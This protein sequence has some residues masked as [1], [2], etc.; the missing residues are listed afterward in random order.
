M[1]E[2]IKLAFKETTLSEKLLVLEI[3][4]IWFVA[5]FFYRTEYELIAF[6]IA[7]IKMLFNCYLLEKK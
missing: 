4:V 6:T 3:V 1:K 5:L 7:S 2:E